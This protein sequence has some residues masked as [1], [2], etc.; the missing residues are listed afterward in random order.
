[1]KGIII[2][3]GEVGLALKA[4]LEQFYPIEVFDIKYPIPSPEGIEI[5]HICFPYSDRFIDE[6]KKYQ[7]YH[8]PKFTVIHSTVPVGTSRQCD[9]AY[10]PIRGLH[11]FLQEGI[12]TFVKILAGPQASEVADYF[13]KAGI[14]VLLFDKQEEA[15]AGKLFDTEYYKKCIEFCHRVKEYCDKHK[16]NFN[17]VYTLFNQTYNEGYFN[18]GY[19]EYIRPVLQPIM[20][21]I[22]GH[23]VEQ[24]SK[25]LKLE[26]NGV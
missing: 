16:L 21:P 4:I 12:L 8:K 11:P 2:G 23:C 1:M 18:L 20:K 14:K 9:A 22:G 26:E 25:L 15:E 7:E 3:L 13:R 19:F 17:E 24:N 10:S 5:M 6:V